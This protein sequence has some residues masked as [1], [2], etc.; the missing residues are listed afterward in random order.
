MTAPTDPNRTRAWEI[1]AALAVILVVVALLVVY[2]PD[3]RLKARSSQGKN[4]LKQLGLAVHNYHDTYDVFPQGGIYADNGTPMHSWETRLIP[5]MESS[6]MYS[7]IDFDQPWDAPV[8][9][10]W[11]CRNLPYYQN[12]AIGEQF[13]ADGYG[14]GHYAL[15]QRVMFRNG[16]LTFKEITD[17]A[18][19]TL[20]IG[21]ISAGFQPWAK[22]GN[23]RDPAAGLSGTP[24][25]FGG[26]FPEGVQ[27]VMADGSVRTLSR[28]I[29]PDVL[30]ALATP[31]G[32]DEVT[33]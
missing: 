14:L 13:D 17:G 18:S 7:M 29:D 5:N 33:P 22:P 32:Q 21:E 20:M 19:H 9:R 15:N 8:N 23:F 28:D 11:F 12:P 24:E 26:R 6:P 31:A 1:L 3:A 4:N 25:N 16:A 27:F 2:V 10:K 30:K